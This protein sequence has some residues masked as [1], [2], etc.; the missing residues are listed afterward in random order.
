MFMILI[1]FLLL[2]ALILFYYVQQL[3]SILNGSPFISSGKGDVRQMIKL[4]EL[5]PTDVVYD[6]GSGDGRILFA[7]G[8]LCRRAIGVEINMW[9]TAITKLK[10]FVTGT[11]NI[12]VIRRSFFNVPLHDA[13]VIFVYLLP[14][15]MHRLEKK[16]LSE[17]KPGTRIISKGFPFRGWKARH[18]AD[19]LYLYVIP[20]KK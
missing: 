10:I 18:T 12:Q 19:G 3:V 9:A 8:G 13:N 6:L 11:K 20:A 14:G 2:S 17:L 15:M 16:L 1:F 5:K 4:A 7:A